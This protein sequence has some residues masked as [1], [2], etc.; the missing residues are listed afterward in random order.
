MGE[1]APAQ[2]EAAVWGQGILQYTPQVRATG[3]RLSQVPL[4]AM[5]APPHVL[6]RWIEDVV[7]AGVPQ[8]PLQGQDL[9]QPVWYQR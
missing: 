4:S 2:A 6:H 5:T 8:P 1:Q 9:Q 3:P 7:P